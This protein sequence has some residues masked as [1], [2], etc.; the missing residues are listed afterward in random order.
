MYFSA[1]GREELI[2]TLDRLLLAKKMQKRGRYFP[3]KERFWM[4]RRNADLGKLEQLAYTL[5]QTIDARVNIDLDQEPQ[6]GKYD[7]VYVFDVFMSELD[8]FNNLNRKTKNQSKWK[9][10][11]QK[12]IKI[13]LEEVLSDG[14]IDAQMKVVLGDIPNV[15]HVSIE[16]VSFCT[17]Y[18]FFQGFLDFQ[19]DLIKLLKQIKQKKGRISA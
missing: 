10:E 4:Q 7:E 12:I 18:T 13:N 19:T 14:F 3:D 17:T 8:E 9:E 11:L 16:S 6:V 1:E 15:L 2:D 5:E